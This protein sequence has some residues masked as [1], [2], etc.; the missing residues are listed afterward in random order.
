MT[1][2]TRNLVAYLKSHFDHRLDSPF[3]KARPEQ[4][5]NLTLKIAMVELDHIS[6]LQAPVHVVAIRVIHTVQIQVERHGTTVVLPIAAAVHASLNRFSADGSL[7]LGLHSARCHSAS[8]R[9]NLRHGYRNG[10]D[11]T[12]KMK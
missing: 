7:R 5:V 10:Q 1:S 6:L 3:G 8:M 4:K 2:G 12:S 9:R 11:E